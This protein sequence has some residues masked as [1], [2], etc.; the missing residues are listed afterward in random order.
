MVLTEYKSYTVVEGTPA[1]DRASFSF[2][3][4][5]WS[6]LCEIGSHCCRRISWLKAHLAAVH[7][8]LAPSN[9]LSDRLSSGGSL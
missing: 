1:T 4:C 7:G 5:V 3:S 9:S 6:D 8:Y 2:A